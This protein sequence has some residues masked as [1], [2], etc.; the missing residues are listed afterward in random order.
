M[1]GAGASTRTWEII[2]R[3]PKIPIIAPSN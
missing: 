1:K 2:D 3:I